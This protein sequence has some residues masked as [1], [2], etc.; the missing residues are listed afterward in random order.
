MFWV[1]CGWCFT[2]EFRCF[3]YFLALDFGLVVCLCL[4]FLG[5]ACVYLVSYVWFGLLFLFVLLMLLLDL[6]TGFG[7]FVVLLFVG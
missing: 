5:C 4:L 2:C 6:P 1:C 7:L 3:S